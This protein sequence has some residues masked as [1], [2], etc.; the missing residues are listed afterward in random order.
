[1][2][3]IHIICAVLWVF[4]GLALV[5]A[6]VA[7]LDLYGGLKTRDDVRAIAVMLAVTGVWAIVAFGV[8]VGPWLEG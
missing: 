3:M 4:A 2:L 8:F 6:W 5:G 1:M 7:A